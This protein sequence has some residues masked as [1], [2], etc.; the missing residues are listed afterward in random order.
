MIQNTTGVIIDICA[1]AVCMRCEKGQARISIPASPPSL[2]GDIHATIAAVRDL[3]TLAKPQ[4]VAV[5]NLIVSNGAQLAPTEV[6]GLYQIR[7]WVNHTVT[8]TM[9]E[10]GSA[11]R[12]S[13]AEP[14]FHPNERRGWGFLPNVLWRK[15][16]LSV[17]VGMLR[18][19]YKG[20]AAEEAI[21]VHSRLVIPDPVEAIDAIIRMKR[22]LGLPHETKTV[23]AI[24]GPKVKLTSAEREALMG[25]TSFALLDPY[26]QANQERVSEAGK[27]YDLSGAG[28]GWV[29]LLALFGVSFAQSAG[30]L[31]YMTAVEIFC[32]VFAAAAIAG[33]TVVRRARRA[34]V[35]AL[36]QTLV[37][38]KQI[39]VAD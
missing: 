24:V 12:I 33:I 13:V 15:A 4:C 32:G 28:I 39:G 7:N 27:G 9:S 11:E 6:F 36:S 19:E 14:D 17:G 8:V 10:E 25:A 34:R 2:L 26:I 22:A 23:I 20:R 16:T 38:L 30:Y 29:I 35:T 18:L 37:P 1:D 21:S 3:T 5:I 31:S